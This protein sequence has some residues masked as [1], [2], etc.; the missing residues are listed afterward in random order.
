MKINDLGLQLIKDWEGFEMFPYLC[1]AGVPTIGYGATYYP[2]T[3]QRVRL[4]DR[5]ISESY[6]SILLEEMVVRYANGVDRYVSSPINE[7]QFSALVSFSYNVGLGAFKGSTLLKRINNDPNDP[8]IT[9]QFMRW[10]K[11]GGTVLKGLVKRRKAE[12]ELYFL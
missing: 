12:N 6:A 9:R 4:D 11:G 10:N 2:D 5:P 1:P 8:D 7:N 3:K